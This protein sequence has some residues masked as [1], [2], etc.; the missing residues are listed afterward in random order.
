MVEIGFSMHTL[1]SLRSQP[2]KHV[3]KRSA[4]GPSTRPLEETNEI[5]FISEKERLSH[6]LF[7]KWP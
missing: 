6:S 2:H 1:R 4:L 7:T 5:G 3:T